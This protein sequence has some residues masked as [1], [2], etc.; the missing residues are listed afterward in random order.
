VLDGAGDGIDADGVADV[1]RLSKTIA[2]AASRSP[3]MFC[4]A[5]ATAMPLTPS[6]V[7]HG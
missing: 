6:P 5:S 1:E 4:T 2:S 3:R 7:I